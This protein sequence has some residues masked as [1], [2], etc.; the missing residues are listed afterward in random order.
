MCG[1]DDQGALARRKRREPSRTAFAADATSI[2]Q[3]GI[4]EPTPV[5]RIV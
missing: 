5:K 4:A 2:R 3:C 1:I